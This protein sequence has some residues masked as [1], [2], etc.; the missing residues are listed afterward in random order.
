MMCSTDFARSGGAV[1]ITAMTGSV[2]VFGVG[3]RPR[4][5]V[6]RAV[7]EILQAAR[8]AGCVVLLQARQVDDLRRLRVATMLARYERVSRSP[9]QSIS[10]KTAGS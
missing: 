10:Q 5:V 3:V 1:H 7:R 4:D 6:E 2:Y 9:K 8:D